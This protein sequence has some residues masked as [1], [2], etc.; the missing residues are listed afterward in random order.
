[1]SQT[2]AQHTGQGL[3]HPVPWVLMPLKKG[4]VGSLAAASAPGLRPF[5][6][7]FWR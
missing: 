3:G 5:R 7:G 2:R 4:K 1:M 6:P